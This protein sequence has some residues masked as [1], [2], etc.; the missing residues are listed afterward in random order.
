MWDLHARQS[1]G[2]NGAVHAHNL[3]LQAFSRA[4]FVGLAS[5]LLLL[6]YIIRY[7]FR[8]AKVTGGGS[9]ALL[10]M[11]LVRSITE[12]P[13]QPNGILGGE[14]FA[15]M[16]LLVYSFDRAAQLNLTDSTINVARNPG[17]GRIV[18]GLRESAPTEGG[19]R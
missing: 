12:V 15:F 2:L 14:F 1:T 4:G 17:K 9:L 16:A 10:A 6:A 18:G 3:Y 7:S 8:A 11:F 13:L 19:F 5:L